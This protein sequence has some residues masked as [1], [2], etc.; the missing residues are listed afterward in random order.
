MSWDSKLLGEVVDLTQG[1]CINKKSNHLV[2]DEGIPLLRITDMINSQQKIFISPE[3]PKKFIANKDDI[4]FTRTGQVGLVFRN[5]YGIIHNNCFTVSPLN[6]ELSKDYLY[7][8]LRSEETIT[9]AKGL[10]AGAAQ[11]DL[12]H[13]AF[14]SISITYP[15]SLKT[16]KRIADIL[17]AYDD[18]IENNLKRIKLLEQAAQNIYKE[19]FVNLRFPGHE[20]TPINEET[21]LPEGWEEK[22]IIDCEIKIG[23]GN[24]SSKYPRANDFL[25]KGVPFF[26]TKEM[27]NGRLSLEDVKRIS[28]QQHSELTKGHLKSGDVLLSTRGSI[29]KVA[30]VDER[31]EGCNINAQLVFFRSDNV[32]I[33]G[34]FLYCQLSTPI[35]Y[36]K[37]INVGSGS[38]QPQ[39]P[40][41]TLNQFKILV[42]GSDTQKE[43]NSLVSNKFKLLEVLLI[44]NQKLKAARDILLPRLMN[45]TIE[46]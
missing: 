19:W 42:P 46:V 1:F 11:P 17:S 24:Y 12:N 27:V 29:G 31:F 14:K 37:I 43:F 5:Q 7:W 3:I 16:Q 36:K 21:G 4:I 10:A 2:V 38:A 18:L 45:R 26:S 39:L 20:N 25:K 8:F 32:K 30:Y 44:Q 22:R 33:Y 9:K 28:D 40:I 34:K 6:E 23:D 13:G 41:K 35:M 15:K